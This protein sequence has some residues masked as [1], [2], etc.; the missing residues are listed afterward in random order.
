VEVDP[1]DV[2]DW[3]DKPTG[4]ALWNVMQPGASAITK[5]LEPGTVADLYSHY[6]ATR[7]LFGAVAVS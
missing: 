5:Y 6:Q 1:E 2:K 4:K 7:H 3:L